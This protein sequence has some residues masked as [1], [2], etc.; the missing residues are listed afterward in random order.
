MTSNKQLLFGT[1]GVPL[2]S[3]ARSTEAGIERSYELGL[4]C[5]EVEFVQGVRMGAESARAAGKVAARRDIKLSAHAP[6]YINL[7]AQEPGKVISSRERILQ[8]ARITSLLG[9][10]SIVFHAAFYMKDNQSSVY[11][12]V[13]KNLELIMAQLKEEG[14]SVCI[15]PE[16]MGK[17]SQFGTIEEILELSAEIEGIAPAIDFA[18]WHA[19][20]GQANSY[21]EFVAILKQI[22]AKL[23]RTALDNMHMHV[24]GIDYGPKGERKHLVLTESDFRYTELLRAL[25]D[26][27]AGGLLICESP[28]LEED[29][30]LLQQTYRAL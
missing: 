16:V 5:M 27:E 11:N 15:R 23:G 28:N 3:K 9:G 2:S 17:G 19:R 6:Y 26:C 18:H 1:A 25:K 22:E 21:D 8:T 14:N 20:T 30:L 7:N 12:T 10:Q 29:A 4:G 13:K 24:S